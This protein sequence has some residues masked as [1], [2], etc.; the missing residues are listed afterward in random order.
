MTKAQFEFMTNIQYENK[1]LKRQLKE[2]KSGEK[3]LAM[4]AGNKK[5]IEAEYALRRKLELSLAESNIRI[6]K[7]H[8]EYTQVI[9]DMEKEHARELRAKDAR[10]KELFERWQKSEEH[11]DGYLDEI[12]SLKKRYYELGTELE[13][14]EEVNRKLM[15]NL[16][17]DHENSSLP[18]S[19]KQRR[20][21]IHNSREETGKKPGGQ[22]GHE[23]HGRKKYEPTNRI[24][25]EPPKE[26]LESPD[27]EATGKIIRKQI[28]RLSINLIVDELS[29]PEFRDLRT[30]LLVH[31]PFP[32][33]V[34]NDVSY[35]GSIKAVAFMLNNYCNVP[36]EKVRE[37]L[38]EI[39][40]G[41]LEISHGMISGLSKE[42][43]QKTEAEREL[44]FN[45]ILRSPYMCTD[46]TNARNGGKQANVLV[47]G[48][49]T[50]AMYFARRHKGHKGVAGTPVAD[51]LGTLVHDHDKT[52][53][54]YGTNHQECSSHPLRY[55]KGSME[56]EPNLTWNA[57]MRKLLQ[58]MV[59]YRNS[60]EDGA[61][62]DPA[63]VG[64]FK[65]DWR[66][67]LEVARREYEYEP[68][69]KYNKEGYNLYR[70]LEEYMD[71]HFT[72][73]IDYRVPATNNFSERL[74]RLVKRKQQ[75]AMTFRSFEGLGYFCDAMTIIGTLRLKKKNLYTSIAG[76]FK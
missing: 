42:F 53:Y 71:Y 72:F 34:V 16:K 45:E 43:S 8:R 17:R 11:A 50:A 74:L 31:A 19:A 7:L 61:V 3:Y 75:S 10:I 58:E 38:S 5:Q 22:P 41:Q 20:K 33:G 24:E 67:V 64:E 15:I 14:Q 40:G 26:Y 62:P 73:L 9:E 25:L 60:R 18:S 37:F 55:L 23:G 59:H 21:K 46:F 30:N 44:I 32:D 27:F 65:S 52:F 76:Y 70:R 39:T 57:E 12:K 69:S 28:V 66:A 51:Y 35:D 49:P 6:S 48:V 4:K 36:I 63:K 54:K 56:N 1:D 13:E 68:P 47:C 29:T 2:F